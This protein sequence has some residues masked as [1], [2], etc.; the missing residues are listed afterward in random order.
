MILPTFNTHIYYIVYMLLIRDV[1]F[2]FLIISLCM[3][4]L[5]LLTL[6]VNATNYFRVLF[7]LEIM[8]VSVSVSY[9]SIALISGSPFGF[10]MAIVLITLSAIEAAIALS[11]LLNVYYHKY[12]VKVHDDFFFKQ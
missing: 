7:C 12:N 2:L 1:S 3:F 11:L 6:I 9:I 4:F 8:Y 5:A 10:I